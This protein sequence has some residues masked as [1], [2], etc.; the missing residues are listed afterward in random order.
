MKNFFKNLVTKLAPILGAGAIGVCPLCWIGS[1][2]LLTYV[3]LGALIPV[4]RWI[5]FGLIALGGIGFALDHRSHR[6]PYPLVLL[7]LGAILLYVGRYVFASTWGAWQIWG[8]GA[9]LIIVAVA[10][11]KWLFRKPRPEQAHSLS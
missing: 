6:N 1:A 8:P 11:N 9:A 5:G 10:Y 2:S 4:W 7:I 3:G